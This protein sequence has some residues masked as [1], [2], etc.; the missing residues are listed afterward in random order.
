MVFFFGAKRSGLNNGRE[1]VERLW[2]L[3]ECWKPGRSATAD[4]PEELAG[5]KSSDCIF[6]SG[7][8]ILRVK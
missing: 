3:N 7:E 8:F 4:T 2:W 6:F 5:G 1:R